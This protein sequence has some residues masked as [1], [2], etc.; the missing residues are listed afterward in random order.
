MCRPKKIS[1]IKKDFHP[2]LQTM[3]AFILF[4]SREN[5]R[6]ALVEHNTVLSGHHIRVDLAE[7]DKKTHDTKNCI[8]VGNLP[9]S[10]EEESLRQHFES[11]CGQVDYVRVIRDAH[12]K[13]CKGFGYV[14]FKDSESMAKALTLHE[15]T[16]YKERTLRIFAAQN[17]DKLK[18]QKEKRSSSNELTKGFKKY[19]ARHKKVKK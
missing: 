15:K 16:T 17:I 11:C 9:L 19:R 7:P 6:K 3:T 5:A 10:T 12:Y 4:D 8:F 18:K 13:V 1:W 2:D 14:K